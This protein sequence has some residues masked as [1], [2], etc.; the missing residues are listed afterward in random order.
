[1]LVAVVS[2]KGSPGVTRLAM[3]LTALWP[4][5]TFPVL[6]E[7]D[8][9]GGTLAARFGLAAAPSLTSLAAAAFR[10]PEA[11]LL[12]GH[13][14]HLPGGLP[15]IVG[16]ADPGQVRAAAADLAAPDGLLDLTRRDASRVAVADCG[17]LDV[18]AIS[19]AV[20]VAGEVLLLA[21]PV[22][23]EVGLLDAAV[24]AL[25]SA[26]C[27]T[28]LVLRGEGYDA[29][30]LSGVLGVEVAGV[31]PEVRASGIFTRRGQA[32]YA[33][34]VRDV[35]VRLAGPAGIAEDSESVSVSAVT[36]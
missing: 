24:K 21:R 10:A 26:G 4:G 8:A 2:V 3:A 27:R 34:A 29:K 28:R 25:R 19:P 31:L 22:P 15:L 20:R 11:G 7:C 13:V 32:A 17:R 14:Q 35:A 6:V 36:R 18:C 33:R 9:A 30:E 12:A 23:E 16:P 1:M 5:E